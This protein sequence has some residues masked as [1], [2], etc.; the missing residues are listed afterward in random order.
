M[1]T[2]PSRRQREVLA[3]R[4]SHRSDS[5]FSRRGPHRSSL[6]AES[7]SSS[8]MRRASPVRSRRWGKSLRRSG[9]ILGA[10]VVVIILAV[11]LPGV[12]GNSDSF[13]APSEAALAGLS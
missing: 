8:K 12:F 1:D 4:S 6:V 10:G 9:L 11:T 7:Y 2:S 3:A 5:A 13:P